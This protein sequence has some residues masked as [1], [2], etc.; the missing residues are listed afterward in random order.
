MDKLGGMFMNGYLA[1]GKPTDVKSEPF[2][3]KG[4]HF[5]K[6]SAVVQNIYGK[7][8]GTN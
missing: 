6:A 3:E 2:W 8:A 5:D 7:L 1:L 4:G